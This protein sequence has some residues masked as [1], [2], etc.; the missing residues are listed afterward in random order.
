MGLFERAARFLATFVYFCNHI[1]LIPLAGAALLAA[2]WIERQLSLGESVVNT[3][4]HRAF[5]VADVALA[6]VIVVAVVTPLVR[7]VRTAYSDLR[8]GWGRLRCIL[9]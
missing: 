7:Q 3:I 9:A 5:N 6:A 2:R 1:V 8:Q 4:V